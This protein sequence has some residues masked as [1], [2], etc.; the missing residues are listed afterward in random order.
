[1]SRELSLLTDDQV[2]TSILTVVKVTATRSLTPKLPAAQH[3]EAD[4]IRYYLES[5]ATFGYWSDV[6]H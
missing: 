2:L 1:M 4:I 5:Y 6:I 3:T